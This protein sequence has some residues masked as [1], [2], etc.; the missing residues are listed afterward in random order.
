MAKG[1]K[2]IGRQYKRVLSIEEI[3]QIELQIYKGISSSEIRETFHLTIVLFDSIYQGLKFET[4]R[5]PSIGKWGHKTE[6]YYTEKELLKGIPKYT[7]KEL[8]KHEKQF[9]L[10]YNLWKK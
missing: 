3:A 4:K 1:Q 8:S 2:F 10:N 6:S 5:H 7:F 9:Y